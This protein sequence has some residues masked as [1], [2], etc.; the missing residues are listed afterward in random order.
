MPDYQDQVRIMREAEVREVTGLCSK[1]RRKM[2]RLGEFP[3]PVWITPGVTGY[4]S[5]E[6]QRWLESRREKR[7]IEPAPDQVTEGQE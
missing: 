5:D 1:T 7:S 4:M 3:S 2:T 6:I